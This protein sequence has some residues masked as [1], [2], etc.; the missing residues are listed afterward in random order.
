MR[1]AEKEDKRMKE[2]R[3][4]EERA[5]EEKYKVEMMRKFAEDEKLEQIEFI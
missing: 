5:L 2:E 3:A 4:A 1:L